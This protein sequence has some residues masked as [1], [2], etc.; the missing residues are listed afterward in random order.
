MTKMHHD[1]K[2]DCD[3]EVVFPPAR[4]L[5]AED[6][7][8]LRAMMAARLRRDGCEVIEARNGD[9]AL[10]LLL[11]VEEGLA[12]VPALD[13]LVSDIRMPG[14]SGLD[15][16]AV[17]RARRRA[18]RVLFVTAYPDDEVVRYAEDLDAT[19]LAKP[20]G[21]SRLSQAARDALDRSPS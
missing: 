17:L 14:L 19:I 18:T 13:L 15:L 4:V 6:D 2:L 11:A 5:I 3:D 9:Q 12:A 21:L 16:L 20:F 7:D 1:Q 10:D 8:A